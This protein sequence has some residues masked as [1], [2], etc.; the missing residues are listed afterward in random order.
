MLFI[1]HKASGE[2]IYYA[3]GIFLL[4]FHANANNGK[5]L[6]HRVDLHV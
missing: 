1:W 3:V 6:Y 5:Y 2:R 4:V